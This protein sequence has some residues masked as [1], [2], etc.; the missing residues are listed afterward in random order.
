MARCVGEMKPA[1]HRANGATVLKSIKSWHASASKDK[2]H[3]A[4]TPEADAD[5]DFRHTSTRI[6]DRRNE[7]CGSTS[8]AAD[9]KRIGVQEERSRLQRARA[10]SKREGAIC[11]FPRG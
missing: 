5:L 2:W 9:R 3:T 4:V 11:L 7:K 1:T 10:G 6:R 8:L